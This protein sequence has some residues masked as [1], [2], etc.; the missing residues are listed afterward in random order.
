MVKAV[1]GAE[2]AVGMDISDGSR[3][4]LWLAAKNVKVSW[5]EIL[6]VLETTVVCGELQQWLS[7]EYAQQSMK[8]LLLTQRSVEDDVIG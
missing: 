7:L 5:L 2:M 8:H 4:D 1:N 6:Q 3:V